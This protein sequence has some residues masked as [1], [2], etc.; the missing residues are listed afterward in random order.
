MRG[1]TGFV[2]LALSVAAC[3]QTVVI[4]LSAVDAGGGTDGGTG[5]PFCS[6]P[7][8]R[9][10]SRSHPR[11][12]SRWTGRDS[13]NGRF[14]DS[15]ALGRRRATRSTCTPRLPEGRLASATRISR[16]RIC[17]FAGRCCAAFERAQP[18][19][20]WVSTWHCTFAIRT[21]FRVSDGHYQRP[22]AAALY[23]C[24]LVFNSRDE[25]MPTLHPPD[26]ERRPDCGSGQ[27]PDVSDGGDDKRHRLARQLLVSTFVVAPGPVWIPTTGRC[28]RRSGRSRAA[29]R[30]N[31]PN[32]H[33][34]VRIRRADNEIGDIIRTIAMDACTLDL[35]GV[36]IQETTVSA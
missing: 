16:L 3:R 27:D 35:E 15:S 34:G 19:L 6:G 10:S 21:S 5:G 1:V 28:L 31:R 14:G 36:R 24:S 23:N 13:M 22:T 12:W 33:A 8:D 29:P 25:T 30:R 11:S 4:D 17:F 26:H 9:L 18:E 7:A 32:F 20:R 2:V